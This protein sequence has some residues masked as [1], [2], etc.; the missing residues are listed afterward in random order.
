[1]GRKGVDGW[2]M[3]VIEVWGVWC[4]VVDGVEKDMGMIVGVEGCVGEVEGLGVLGLGVRVEGVWVVVV[5]EDV[6]RSD[7]GGCVGV[8]GKV[9]EMW[10][11]GV[12]CDKE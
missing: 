4:L 5:E 1:M 9:G 7:G 6:E 8:V 3:V 11:C 10:E 2:D 12:G